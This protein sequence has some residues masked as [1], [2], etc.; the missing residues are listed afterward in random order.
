MQTSITLE[1]PSSLILR[2]MTIS[3]SY[4]NTVLQCTFIAFLNISSGMEKTCM[5][6]LLGYKSRL[7]DMNTKKLS[8][9]SASAS[10][11]CVYKSHTHTK[12]CVVKQ[13]LHS[14]VCPIRAPISSTDG[15]WDEGRVWWRYVSGHLSWNFPL[16]Q[17]PA[18]G[19]SCSGVTDKVLALKLYVS[20]DIS[21]NLTWRKPNKHE[22]AT[23]DNLRTGQTVFT[24]EDVELLWQVNGKW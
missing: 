10:G 9:W 7:C 1:L 23:T 14:M 24:Q 11:M 16:G 8:K 18:L 6:I 15:V 17:K 5:T 2:C 19:K 21:F 13:P 22:T 4:F 20:P 3:S 12:Y